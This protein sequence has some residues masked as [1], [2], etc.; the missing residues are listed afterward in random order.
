METTP[1]KMD[2]FEK[3]DILRIDEESAD[4]L[5]DDPDMY[6]VYGYND[7][8]GMYNIGSGSFVHQSDVTQYAISEDGI[9][10]IG[11]EELEVVYKLY[12]GFKKL[13]PK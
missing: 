3:Y 9:L 10:Y 11:Y 6:Q 12:A 13:V 1:N 8:T 5:N 2:Y 4:A 7:R